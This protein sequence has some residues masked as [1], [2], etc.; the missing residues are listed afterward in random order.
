MKMGVR[1]SRAATGEDFRARATANCKTSNKT[2]FVVWQK[3][4]IQY[5][6]K[7]ENPL[8]QLRLN[9]HK[10]YYNCR[11]ADKKMGR[12]LYKLCHT[13][14]DVMVMVIEQMSTASAARKKNLEASES[15]H[16]DH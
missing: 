1:F 7:T 11:L 14:G 10:S 6:G 15:L 9:G 4:G 13:F 12:H 5:I 8:Q 16:F 2:H 3:C